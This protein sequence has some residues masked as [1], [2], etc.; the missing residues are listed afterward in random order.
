METVE[1]NVVEALKSLREAMRAAY[2]SNHPTMVIDPAVFLRNLK[3]SEETVIRA[4]FIVNDFYK[5]SEDE[6]GE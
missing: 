4:D 5:N 6:R 1:I 2:R 3:F